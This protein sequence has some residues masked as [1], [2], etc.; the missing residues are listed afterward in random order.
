MSGQLHA[1]AAL[2]RGK[3]PRYPLDR[4]L[5]GRRRE[6]KILDPTGTRTRTP[7]SPSP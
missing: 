3:S 4:A 1:P 6:E 2:T 7:R 5:G